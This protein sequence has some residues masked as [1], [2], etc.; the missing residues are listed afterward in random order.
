MKNTLFIL[1]TY[2]ILLCVVSCSAPNELNKN[3]KIEFSVEGGI[4]Y[5]G[6][7]ENTDMSV[8]P[9]AQAPEEAIVDAFTG[10]TRSGYHVGGHLAIPLKKLAFE[11]G[12]EYMYNSQSFYYIDAGNF[13]LGQRDLEVSQ[14]MVP[15]RL[16]FPLFHKLLPGAD[17]WIKMGYM[18]QMNL[19]HVMNSGILPE[20]SLNRWSGGAVAGIAIYPFS[21]QNQSRLGF[22]VDAYRGSQI[23]EDYYNQSGFEMPGSSFVRGGLTFKF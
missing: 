11:S 2:T 14:L 5:G 18:G 12:V 21:F 17:A 6:I 19:I 1:A 22:Y 8:V 13:F 7:T 23:F 20:Y 15:L 16:S 10:A 4:N 9:N 3:H